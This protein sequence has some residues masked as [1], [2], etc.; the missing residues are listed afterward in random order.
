MAVFEREAGGLPRMP[1]L[2]LGAEHFFD[3]VFWRLFQNGEVVPYPGGH[4]ALIELPGR[5]LPV[6][7][8]RYLFEMRIRGLRPV[9][10]HPERYQLC[11]SHSTHLQPLQRAGVLPLLDLMSLVG[12]Y[13]RRPKRT[14]RECL[15]RCLHRL[16][17]AFGR[18][19]RP[20]SY[21]TVASPGRRDQRERVVE[22]KPEMHPRGN[23]PLVNRFLGR[24]RP[25]R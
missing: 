21:R 22:R 20:T 17:S 14:R 6:G 2:G 8:D 5:S 25:G 19:P 24:T 23:D 11:F 12:R 13:G 4:A 3:D 18:R 7:I 1:A 15:L 9:L 10:A 16:P